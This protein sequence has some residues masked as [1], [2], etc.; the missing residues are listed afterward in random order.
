[1]GGPKQK[2]VIQYS[3]FAQLSDSHRI[4]DSSPDQFLQASPLLNNA[5]SQAHFMD[6]S[7]M[8]TSG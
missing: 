7:S 1:M 8:V 5:H 6:T 3:S 2:G 4:L